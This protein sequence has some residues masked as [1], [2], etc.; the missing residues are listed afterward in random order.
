MKNLNPVKALRYFTYSLFILFLTSCE[1]ARE[2]PQHPIVINNLLDKTKIF[3]D[4]ALIIFAQDPKYWGDAFKNIYYAALSMGRIKDI[5]TLAVTSEH[6]HKKVWQIA[7][8]KV[9]KYFNESLR[10]VRIKFDYEIFEQETSS[11]FQD[12]EHLQ[13]NATMPFSELIEE[14]RNQIDKKYSQ[15]TCDHSKCCICKSVGAKTCLKGEAVDILEDIQ[16]K[17]TNLIEEK[18]PELTKSKRIE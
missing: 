6:F 18:I 8:K 15:C 7:P 2:S 5:N 14:V 9:R 17:I 10:L 11:Y 3:I 16:R 4:L 13:Q 12:L 1:V